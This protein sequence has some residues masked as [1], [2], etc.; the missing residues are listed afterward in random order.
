[1]LSTAA[2]NALLKTL[3]EPPGHVVFVLAT[4]DPQKVLPTI[5]SRTQHF[6]FRLLG[7]E[8][9]SA[10]LHQVRSASGLAVPDEAIDAAVRRG[11]GSARDALSALD[12][13]AAGGVVDDDIEVLAEL[14][15]AL[16][17]RD[18]ARALVAVAHAVE[19]GRDPQRLAA[20]LAEYLRQ[21]FL[22]IV[23]G[24]LVSLS[25]SDRARV[26]DAASRMGLPALVRASR[27]WAGPR[28]TCA[29][30]PTSASTS[31]SRSSSSPTRRPT[32]P[33]APC[34]NGWNASNAPWPTGAGQPPPVGTDRDRRP[35]FPSKPRPPPRGSPPPTPR[36]PGP[37]S[38]PPARPHHRRRPRSPVT[39]APPPSPAGA[40]SGPDLA[41]RTLGA[42]RRQGAGR[43]P[44]AEHSRVLRVRRTTDLSWRRPP[45]RLLPRAPPPARSRR[46]TSS[47]RCGATGCSPRCPTGPGPGSGWGASSRSTGPRRSSPSPTRRTAP[48]ARRSASGRGRPGLALRDG[49]PHPS[50][51]RQ[52]ERRRPERAPPSSSAPPPRQAE[53]TA[54]GVGG[55]CTGDDAPDGLRRSARRRHRLGPARRRST[56]TTPPTSSTPPC[57][58]PRPSPPGP[59]S[60]PRNGS[61]RP[62][63]APRRCSGVH[64]PAA[65]PGRRARP[66]PRHRAQ[67]GAAH[68]LP[69]AEGG[70]R[71]RQPPGRGH[72]GRQGAHHVVPPVLQRGRGRSVRHLRRLP[73]RR[74]GRCASSRTPATSWRSRRPRSSGVATTSCTA[75]ST[76]S[77]GS[78]R[79]SYA[80]RSCSR[81]STT[82]SHRDHPVHQPEPRRRGHRHVP[83]AAAQAPR[84]RPSPASPAA[85][86][87]AGT[88]STPTSS[89]WVA[90]SRAAARWTPESG[91]SVPQLGLVGAALEG[92][93]AGQLVRRGVE[94]DLGLG[95]LGEAAVAPAHLDVALHRPSPLRRRARRRWPTS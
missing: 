54:R 56:T 72:R 17:E 48:T 81:G 29:T 11:R 13:V 95:R 49:G 76:R 84:V 90:P 6:E 69:P 4:T 67:V 12:Q 26:E 65:V 58:R 25:G 46:A 62:S 18:P 73:T 64:R 53:V 45:C 15:E 40:E 23:A 30:S 61:C 34:S 42:V 2:S 59:G 55:G 52:R 37:A 8:T 22:A 14:A 70:A 21:G 44:P 82:S 88:S 3:E 63:P 9:L 92:E 36:R 35:P 51:R 86:P 78:A 47:C 93:V 50:G 85:C 77:R 94:V 79:T 31:R 87:W 75:R 89:P 41:R 20:D 33:P 1:M 83:G 38:S 32:I 74:H 43:R 5:R 16:A 39:L 60:P 57:W 7:P 10:L 27:A 68:R 66:P 28:S 71:G 91:A 24:E 19:A 80:S